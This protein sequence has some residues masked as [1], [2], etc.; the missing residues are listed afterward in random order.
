MK[1]V[2]EFVGRAVLFMVWIPMILARWFVVYIG[3]IIA[4]VAGFCA[5]TMYLMSIEQWPLRLAVLSVGLFVLT[6]V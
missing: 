5:V 6:A 1:Q 4:Y 3:R 2:F